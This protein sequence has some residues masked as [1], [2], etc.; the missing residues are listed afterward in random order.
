MI[1]EKDLCLHDASLASAKVS[2]TIDVLGR[3][4]LKYVHIFLFFFS[5]SFGC[6]THAFKMFNG[7]QY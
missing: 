2:G 5:L 3:F 1:A 7:T 4:L 6:M